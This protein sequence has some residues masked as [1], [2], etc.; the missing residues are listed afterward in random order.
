MINFR[1]SSAALAL[2]AGT[3]FPLGQAVAAEPALDRLVPA[4]AALVF[5]LEDMPALRERVARSAFGRAWADPDMER[6]IAPLRSHPEYLKLIEQVKTE[7][8]HTP[9]ELLAFATGDVLLT[10]PLS[11]LNFSRAD[12]GAD[13]LL[14]L[15]VGEN[16]SK[17]RELVAKPAETPAKDS[18]RVESVED[19]NGV[20]I[21]LSAP[22]APEPAA[23]ADPAMATPTPEPKP[24]KTFAWALHQGRWFLATD[25]ALV[26]GALDALAAGGLARPL[27]EAETYRAVADRAGGRPD[28][29]LLAD[30]QSAYPALSASLE[31]GKDPSSPPNPLGIEPANILRALGVDALGVLSATGAVL[32]DGSTRGDLVMTYRE[33]RGLVN[34]LA[35]KDGPVAR[36]DWVPASW[37]NVSSQNFSLPDLYAELQAMLDRLS[38]VLAG[39][40]NGQIKAQERQLKIDFAR[41]FVGNL[42]TYVLSGIAM[43]VGASVSNPPPYDE[44]E[45]FFAVSLADAAAFERALEAV[46]ARF[47]P[48]G[49]AGPLE[50]REY[51]GRKLHVFTPPGG[52]PSA[53]KGF[54]YAITD[55]WLMVSVGSAAPLESAL[56][57]L[58]KPDPAAS[59]WAR[60]DVRAALADAPAGAFSVQFADLRPLFASLCALAVKAQAARE[61]DAAP[62]VDAAAQP[63]TEV[64]ARHLSHVV[65]IG[66]RRPGALVIQTSTPAAPAP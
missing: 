53:S 40:L 51:L 57:G 4:D 60:G 19:Y 25:R 36:P 59:F 35:Y 10:V 34:L 27:A 37:I 58:H 32:S 30:F 62:L 55:G 16:E 21:H 52:A 7:T 6:F 61:P 46:K 26:T 1:V 56:Q 43:P 23:P 2:F 9:E 8:G 45:Q 13:V 38:P 5:A 12:S 54:A 28:Y 15:E 22:P 63:S 64:F 11:S 33:A 31:A 39:M 65:T 49:S 14:A 3:V 50:T 17:I 18:A 24:G 48:P 66:E 44:M 42:G 47:I 20:A 41:D 29:L